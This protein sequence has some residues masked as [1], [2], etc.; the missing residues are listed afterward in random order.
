[1]AIFECLGKSNESKGATNT[2]NLMF[3]SIYIVTH[4][5][6][7]EI[8]TLIE[9]LLLSSCDALLH[10]PVSD[11]LGDSFIIETSIDPTLHYTSF[12]I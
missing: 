4:N 9:G 1:M 6:R 12:A 7:L 8:F 10:D 11:V 2:E 3:N 5:E